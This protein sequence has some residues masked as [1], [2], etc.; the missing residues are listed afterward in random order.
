MNQIKNFDIEYTND[1]IDGN[2]TEL[3]NNFLAIQ[4]QEETNK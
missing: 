4:V 2:I 3:P 1:P